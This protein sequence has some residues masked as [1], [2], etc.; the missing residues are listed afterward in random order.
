M[1]SDLGRNGKSRIETSTSV[2]PEPF[3]LTKEWCKWTHPARFVQSAPSSAWS[4]RTPLPSSGSRRPQDHRVGT[5]ARAAAQLPGTRTGNGFNV[6]A[7]PKQ[8]PQ[9][10]L[11]FFV[12]A[13]ALQELTE[14]STIGSPIPNRGGEG[15]IQ[16]VGLHY[17]QRISDAQNHGALHIGP[18]IWLNV[19]ATTVPPAPP[20][21]VRLATIPTEPRSWRRAPPSRRPRARRRSKPSTRPRSR[22][23]IPRTRHEPRVPQGVRHPCRP[24][25]RSARSRTPTSS[26]PRRSSTR[27]SSAR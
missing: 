26:S 15:D 14:F 9:G 13:N 7:L 18:G 19:P 12:L 3:M 4:S 23:A 2:T 20:S 11:P 16:F 27:R 25:S 10:P 17:L 5:D 8:P 22:P 1:L 6:I 24:A 21:V